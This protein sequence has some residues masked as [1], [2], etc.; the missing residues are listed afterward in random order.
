LVE[1]VGLGCE[2]AGSLDVAVPDCGC[3]F[4]HGGF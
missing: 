2:L 3:G 4:D 1:G